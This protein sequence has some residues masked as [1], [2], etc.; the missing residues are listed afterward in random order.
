MTVA[1]STA[2]REIAVDLPGSI[3]VFERHGLDYCCG[4]KQSLADACADRGLD[5]ERVLA[6]LLE[7]AGGDTGAADAID[8]SRAEAPDLIDHLLRTHHVYLK[9]NM[10]RLAALA[11]KVAR[12]HGDNHPE[13]VA[14]RE[15]YHKFVADMGPHMAKEEQILF[16]AILQSAN[17]GMAFPIWQPI[18]VMEAEHDEAGRDLARLRDLTRGF[19]VPEDACTSYRLLLSGLADLERDTHTHIHKENNIL[20]PRVLDGLAAVR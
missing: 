20:F 11:D 2:V 4:G 8:W 18:A 7:I 6:E 15:V 12:V 19:Q 14:V 17:G 1:L 16:P 13:L 5:A 3:A 9:E 10:P